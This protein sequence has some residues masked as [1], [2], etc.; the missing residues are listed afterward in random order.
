MELS[1]KYTKTDGSIWI[2]GVQ[3]IVRLLLEQSQLDRKKGVRTA[4]FVSGYRGSPLGGVDQ[5]LSR[6]ANRLKGAN[7]HFEP[8]VN[9]DLAATAVWGTQQT[10]LYAGAQYEGV[11]GLWYGKSP[12]LDRSGDVF[13]HANNAGVSQYGGVVAIVG[14]D[15]A[16]KSSTL[17]SA[18][19]G[20]LR[21]FQVPV[22]VPS[23]VEDLIRLGLAGWALSR[24]SGC[25]AALTAVTAVMDSAASVPL[26][27]INRNFI[28]PT[29][30]FEPHIRLLDTPREQEA[31]MIQKLELALK[32]SAA[33]NLNDI[34]VDSPNPLATLVGTGKAFADLRQALLDLGF[35]NDTKLS[36]AG[37]RLVK[38]G[39]VW[40]LDVSDLRGLLR[41]SKRVL[42]VEGKGNFLE[43]ALKA[44]LYGA[45]A[46]EIRGKSDDFESY[47]LAT[48]GEPNSDDIL[49]L[50]VRYFLDVGV[51]LPVPLDLGLRYASPEIESP[52]PANESR[53]PLF[54]PGCPHSVST[55]IP[56]G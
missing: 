28:E 2:G 32:F 19:A 50:L 52:P 5:A 13:R 33:N 40:P 10:N 26:E 9:E 24:Y 53:K 17:P 11:F 27:A 49:Q 35:D 18:S 43:E 3:A 51:A 4:G 46:P 31:R 8:G 45:N 21:E 14:D 41:D 15:P 36:E 34:V 25:W 47:L 55:M 54:C 56:E 30:H 42:V 37:I 22:L 16:C 6:E 44:T 48:T 12:G 38:M 7:I 29:H 1:D 20:P 23:D 39:M